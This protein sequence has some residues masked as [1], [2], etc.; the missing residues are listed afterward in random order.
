MYGD[1]NLSQLDLRASKRVGFGR[2]R[3]RVDFDVYN[4]FNSS[5]PFTVSSTYSTRGEQPRGCVRPT[6]CRA[7]SSS[8][9]DSSTSKAE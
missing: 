6:C 2:Y 4:V 5:W 8:S 9:A 1:H 3:L 7:A